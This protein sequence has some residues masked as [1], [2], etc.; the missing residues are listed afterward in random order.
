MPGHAGSMSI[1]VIHAPVGGWV[2]FFFFLIF[3]FIKERSFAYVSMLHGQSRGTG[4][5]KLHLFPFR[6]GIVFII[7]IITVVRIT[8][9]CNYGM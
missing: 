3:Y 5:G 8:E 6:E 9:G 1:V 7:I 4:I 2:F